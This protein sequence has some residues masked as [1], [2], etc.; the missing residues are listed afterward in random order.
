MVLGAKAG[1][2]CERDDAVSKVSR[3]NTDGIEDD[4]IGHRG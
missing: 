2:V 3:K 4:F 1:L